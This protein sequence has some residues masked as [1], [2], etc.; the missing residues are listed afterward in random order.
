M[1]TGTEHFLARL[2][3]GRPHD[4]LTGPD[5]HVDAFP[6]CFPGGIHGQP[7]LAG[8]HVRHE[9]EV[10][11]PAPGHRLQPHRLPDAGVRGV[12]DASGT[13]GLLAARL[14]ALLG[15]IVHAHDD[16][17]R[18]GGP[19]KKRRDVEAEGIVAAPVQTHALA[20]EEHLAL[21]IDGPEVE[22]DLPAVPGRRHGEHAPIPETVVVLHHAGKGR[23]DRVG[24]EDF[25]G[26]L[27]SRRHGVLDRLPAGI[28]RRR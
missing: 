27:F 13:R 18:L 21:V 3:R 14:A 9:L 26:Q 19:G 1:G 7:E 6:G 28:A 23:L 11:D 12:D 5:G 17:L 2:A 25:R 24:H 4:R 22:D 8:I 20:V 10:A 16:F 15:G